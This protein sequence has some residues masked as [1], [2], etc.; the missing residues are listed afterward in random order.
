M[1]LIILDNLKIS[2]AV[3]RLYFIFNLQ[4]GRQPVKV[5]KTAIG[6]DLAEIIDRFTKAGYEVTARP[7]Q[8]RGDAVS[9]SKYACENGFDLVLCAGGDGT[10]SECID[11]VMQSGKKVPVGYIP[12][13][14]TNDFSKGLG[15]PD[16]ILDA[17]DWII[18]GIN[19]NTYLSCDIGSLNKNRHFTYIAAFGAFTN[20][21][22]ETSQHWK[23]IFGHS[24]YLVNG[25]TQLTTIKS[26]KV[27]IECNDEIIED[28]FAFGM[29]TNTK[30]VGGLFNCNNFLLDD[31][32]YEVT[33]VKTPSNVMQLQKILVSLFNG[34][35][36]ED[37]KDYI[38]YFK[39][40]KLKITSLDE[41]PLIWN[42]DGEYGGEFIESEIENNQK[43]VTFIVGSEY[44][45]N[46]SMIE[47][48][49][50]DSNSENSESKD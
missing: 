37:A 8:D 46:V 47:T 13:G 15:V 38:R 6:G 41:N 44:T 27:R 24:A 39:T 19:N 20:V 48:N 26:R 45:E 36:P 4:A 31:G 22:Y 30:K 16:K 29:I 2:K 40:G 3:K 43:A 9:A 7:T 50:I 14:T 23:N 1:E 28:D 21:T 33:F 17:C 35:R 42:L 49:S 12:V 5:V 11:G 10:L 32:I 18:D 25:A 34:K